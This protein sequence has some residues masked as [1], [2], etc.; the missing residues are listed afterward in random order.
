MA[1]QL[2]GYASTSVE[3]GTGRRHPLDTRGGDVT[4]LLPFS[5]LTAAINDVVIRERAE[6]LFIHQDQF[7]EM[8]R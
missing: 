8:I 3:R 5:R 1:I 7:P 4:A 2:S 6:V